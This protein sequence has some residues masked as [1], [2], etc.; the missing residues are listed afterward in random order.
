MQTSSLPAGPTGCWLLWP[1]AGPRRESPSRLTWVVAPVYASARARNWQE[2]SDRLKEALGKSRESFTAALVAANAYY[3]SL[4]SDAAEEARANIQRI[5]DAIPVMSD[6]ADNDLQ[7]SALNALKQQ[8]TV[9]RHGLANLAD[10]FAKQA[11]R[12][13]EKHRGDRGSRTPTLTGLIR[14]LHT[15]QASSSH[16]RGG[17]N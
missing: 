6:L 5:E 9:L 13:G 11:R 17:A 10:L 15:G 7:R 12:L 4:A 8:A 14:R 2:R 16:R 3:L 1:N